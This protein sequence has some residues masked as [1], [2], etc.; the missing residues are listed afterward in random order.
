MAAIPSPAELERIAYWGQF[1]LTS[2]SCLY[3]V[4]VFDM[5]VSLGRERR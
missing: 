4:L 1:T 2:Y 3:A 5:V